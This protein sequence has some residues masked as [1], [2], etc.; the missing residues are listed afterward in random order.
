MQTQQ[1]PTAPRDRKQPRFPGLR[2]RAAQSYDFPAMAR[3]ANEIFQHER[4]IDYFNRHHS[5]K[6]GYEDEASAADRLLAAET[7]WRLADMR[8]NRRTP[9]RHFLVATYLKQPAVYLT[10]LHGAQPKEEILGWAEW[11]DPGRLILANA[12]PMSDSLSDS[13]QTDNSPAKLEGRLNVSVGEVQ[14]ILKKMRLFHAKQELLVPPNGLAVNLSDALDSFDRAATNQPEDWK[15]WTQ[16]FIPNCLGQ[17]GDIHGRHLVLRSLVVSTARWDDC[18]GRRL[19]KWGT[20]RANTHG[21]DIQTLSSGISASTADTFRETGFVELGRLDILRDTQIV[22]GWDRSRG[23]ES[24]GQKS[25]G[26]GPRKRPLALCGGQGA[27]KPA[28]KKSR[29]VSRQ[30]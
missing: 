27:Q 1:I 21:W 13:D 19:L 12:A 6:M 5:V 11:Q 29:P 22:L 16:Q 24:Q 30:E 7:D 3:M 20:L 25:R 4:D 26:Q 17:Y 9:G 28:L 2:V 15:R 23:Q 10:S 18:V 14:P 8:K